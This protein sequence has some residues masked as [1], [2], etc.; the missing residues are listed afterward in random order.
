[1]KRIIVVLLVVALGSCN[2]TSKVNQH[3]VNYLDSIITHI[4]TLQWVDIENGFF[5]NILHYHEKFY[6]N[7]YGFI[8]ISKADCSV[9]NGKE[10]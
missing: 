1:M 3:I 8:Y 4:D 10:N 5:E 7:Q 2:N 9:C 6:T